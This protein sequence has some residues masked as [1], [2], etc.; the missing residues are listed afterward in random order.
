VSTLSGEDQRAKKR[1]RLSFNVRFNNMEYPII[2]DS[3]AHYP[4]DG[5][6]TYCKK[7]TK[8]NFVAL[9]GGALLKIPGTN[10]AAPDDNLISTFSLLDHGV[11]NSGKPLLVCR[12]EAFGQYELYFCSTSCLRS[13]F[14]ALVDDFEALK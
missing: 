14:N 12:N 6:C 11:T 3:D 13:F 1:A 9:N 10:M 2:K 5:T 7:P 8:G 4:I